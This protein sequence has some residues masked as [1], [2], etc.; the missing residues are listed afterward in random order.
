MLKL[1][2]DVLGAE[3]TYSVSCPFLAFWGQ[4]A[5]GGEARGERQTP[6]DIRVLSKTVCG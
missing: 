3:N 2:R 4:R 1:I 5:G 6:V